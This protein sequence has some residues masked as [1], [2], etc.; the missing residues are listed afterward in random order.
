[1][2]TV[3]ELVCSYGPAVVHFQK[4]N[5]NCQVLCTVPYFMTLWN[6]KFGQKSVIAW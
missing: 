5:E 3:L 2:I 4:D 6:Q 1:M